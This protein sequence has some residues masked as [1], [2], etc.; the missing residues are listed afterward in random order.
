MKKI[1]CLCALFLSITINANPISKNENSA[2]KGVVTGQVTD[3]DTKEVLPYVSIVIKDSNNKVLTGGITNDKGEFKIDKIPLGNNTVE[4]Q[5]IGYK[6]EIRKINFTENNSKHTLGLISLGIDA[7]L[8]DEVVVIAEVSTVVQK[9]DR[10]VIN[11]GKDLTSAGT[12]ASELL[13]NVQSVSVDS[14]TGNISLRGNENV[15]VLVD[16]KPTNLNTAQLLKQIPSTSIKQIELITNP[17]AKY[18]PEGMSGII[19][20][21]LHKGANQG[22]NG[23]VNLGLTHGEN[24]KFNGSIDMNY[25]TGIVNFFA[26]YGYNTGKSDNYG[27]VNRTDNN[28]EQNFIMKGDNTSH[29][30]KVGADIYINEKNTFSLYTTQNISDNLSNGSTKIYD[31]NVMAIDS[32]NTS[33][34]ESNSATYNFNYKT[35]FEK[36]GHDLEFEASFSN[37]KGPEDAINGDYIDPTDVF[38]NYVADIDNK[39]SNQLYNI[40]YTNPLSEN[41]K[42]ELGAE[43]RNNH[44]E[45][46]QMT[47]QHEFDLDNNGDQIPDPSNPGDYLT[48]TTPDSNFDYVRDI[49]STYATYSH[50][51]DKI[52][53]QI[54]ARFEQYEIVGSFI[55]GNE[56]EIVED[57]IFSVYPSAFFTFNPSEKNQF[58]VSYSRRVDRPSLGQINPIRE[59]S[60][61]RITSVGNP[62]LK[63]QF[64][65]SFEFNY[66][67]QLEKGSVTFG[68][69]YRIV[70]D[71]ITRILNIDPLDTDKVLL[72]Y[73]NTDNSNRY[74]FEASTNYALTQWWR[75]NASVDLY[76]QKESGTANG[77]ELEV[78]NNAFNARLSNSFKVSKNFRLQLFAM[79]RGGGKSIQFEIDPM[80]MINTGASLNV[81]KGKGTFTFR[82][83]D[84]FEGMKFAFESNNPYPSVGEFNW[85]SRTAYL[86]F[87]YR[88]GG[89][90]SRA[91]RRKNRDKNETEG[92]GGFL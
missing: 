7:A 78:T 31:N 9:I 37:N 16:G 42:L 3:A 30:F 50:Q 46:E 83:N 35:Q 4:I 54:G 53:M 28:S 2:K 49:Y 92:S 15:R 79:Y 21:V 27:Y 86:G 26:N 45:N 19:N 76:I 8:L 65:N 20:I 55:K 33:D 48:H 1:I 13:N 6:T 84:I 90:K 39:R 63:P 91:L 69:F 75:A 56:L 32:Y 80:W 77:N 57:K 81:L 47:T 72:S 70:N 88:F 71:N 89:G 82:V 73:T 17:S 59:W 18:N 66:T 64:T 60:T 12:T 5:F 87:N 41:G 74:G 10:K 14:Q 23:S 25:K 62:N 36:E 29:L 44:S 68:T 24:T 51:F 52:T 61:P 67:R 22:F 58:Q 38:N 85:E 34:S 40:D 43:Y 11:V